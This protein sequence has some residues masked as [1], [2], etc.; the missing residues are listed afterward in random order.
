MKSKYFLFTVLTLIAFIAFTV[1]FYRLSDVPSGFFADE[2]SIGYNAYTIL[3]KGVDE[4][5]IPYPLFF[6]AFGEFK[7]PV[8]I[9]STILFISIFGLNEFSVRLPSVIFGTATITAIYFLTKELCHKR[10]N[11]KIIAII[12]ALFTAISPWHIHFSRTPMEGFMPYILFTT[13]GLYFFLKSQTNIKLLTLSVFSFA[14]SMYCYFPARI[15]IPLFFLSIAIIYS[16]FLL[17]NKKIVI[18]NFTVLLFLLIPLIQFT[19]SSS[20]FAR[21]NQVNIFSQPPEK[22]TI[23]NHVTN[24]YLSHFSLDFLFLKGDIDMPGQFITRH[25]VRGMGELYLFQFP[26]IIIGLIFLIRKKM[27]KPILILLLWLIQYPVGS[28]F[29]IDKNVQAT[30]SIIGVIPFQIISSVGLYYLIFLLS[31]TRKAFAYISAF[32]MFVIISVSFFYFLNLYFVKYPLYSSDFWGLQFGA[33]DIVKY[34]A[35]NQSKYDELVMAP[36]FNAPGI[37]FKFYS[38]NNCMKCKVGLPDQSY[39]PNLKQLFAVT[40]YYLNNHQEIRLSIQKNIFYPNGTIAFR[41]GEIVQ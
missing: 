15:F 5:G 10:K 34:F 36:E 21:W 33:R 28:M 41:I 9:Y 38:P 4:Y 14:L 8:E 1:R 22:T 40:P 25:S 2:A 16:K 6:R 31:K 23:F 29:T 17:Q 26:L 27:Y 7:N 3:T 13:L 12:A 30:R 35:S 19:F 39:K 24:N 37:F 20:G 11:R 32:I 18:L